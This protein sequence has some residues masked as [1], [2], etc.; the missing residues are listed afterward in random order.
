M[1][2]QLVLT[3]AHIH[4][5]QQHQPGERI[6]VDADLA[7]WLLSIGSARVEQPPS[8]PSDNPPAREAQPFQRKEPKP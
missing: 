7:Q 1:K 4:A 8:T 5:G 2:T 6:E 3:R